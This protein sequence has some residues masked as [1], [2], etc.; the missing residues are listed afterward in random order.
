MSKRRG[1]IQVLFGVFKKKGLKDTIEGGLGRKRKLRRSKN[2]ENERIPGVGK[3][4][5]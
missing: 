2:A 1:F 3:S 4:P 5:S